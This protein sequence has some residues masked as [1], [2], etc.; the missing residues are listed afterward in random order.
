MVRNKQKWYVYCLKSKQ[1]DDWI[2]V[3]KIWCCK[4]DNLKKRL[5]Y[6]NNKIWIKF[7]ILYV[8]WSNDI[9]KTENTILWKLRETN[10]CL[11]EISWELFWNFNWDLENNI[12]KYFII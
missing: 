8:M 12:K 1:K 2:Y 6:W 4:K 10:N 5:Y 7:D 9:Y 3:Y 11:H